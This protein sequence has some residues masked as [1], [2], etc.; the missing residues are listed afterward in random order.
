M[1][2]GVD[3]EGKP[4]PSVMLLRERGAYTPACQLQVIL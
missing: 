2:E 1:E 4:Y 3:I